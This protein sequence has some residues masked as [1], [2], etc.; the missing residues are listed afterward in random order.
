MQRDLE[1]KLVYTKVRCETWS[2]AHLRNQGFSVLLPRVR[3]RSGFA[4]LFPRYV[5]IGHERERDIRCVRS[6][7][8]VLHFVHFGD[9]PVKVPVD[10]IDEIRS[11]MN[12][13]G[14]VELDAVQPLFDGRQRERIRMLLKLAEAGFKVRSA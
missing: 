5:F 10:V 1:W 2:E 3:T 12:A 14:V 4:P 8:G 13:Y 9:H 6:T 7:R 11:R